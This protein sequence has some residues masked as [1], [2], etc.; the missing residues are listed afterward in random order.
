MN[1]QQKET[2]IAPDPSISMEEFLDLAMDLN[3]MSMKSFLQDKINLFLRPGIREYMHRPA[4]DTASA[5][6]GEIRQFLQTC[7]KVA[8]K[9]NT[10]AGDGFRIY[11]DKG[12]DTV[13]Q[14]RS[15][16]VDIL[17]PLIR[18]HPA[19]QEI[20]PDSLNTLRIHTV[21][22]SNEVRFFLPVI[23]STGADGAVTD[24]SGSTTRYHVFLSEDGSI[25]RAFREYPGKICQVTDRHH[26]TGYLFRQGQ[27]LPGIPACLECCRK[28]AFYV[29]EMRYI[30]WDVAVTQEGPVI[31][32]AN[33]ISGLF[34]FYQ[35][36]KECIAEA[37]ARSEIERMLAFGM[38]GVPYNRETVCIS[39]PLVK[40]GASL[41]DLWQLY[42]IL[43]QAALHRHGVEFYDRGFIKAGPA[44]RKNCSIRYL[45]EENAVLIQRGQRTD[46][47][48]QPDLDK[49][50]LSPYGDDN[51]HPC[52]SEEDFFAMDQAAMQ[53]AARIYRVLM[54]DMDSG[55]IIE[56]GNE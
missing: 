24:V 35:R 40:T 3:D 15:D 56:E 54:P 34:Y 18:Q 22:S 31:V 6:D 52:V 28:A 23:L 19:Y 33:N 14:I 9:R 21:R 50:G 51:G 11:T 1:P 13:A 2:V 43:L 44:V 17:E 12:A 8:G 48:P 45:E 7:G 5:W 30:G 26:N 38:E 16:G 39:E 27:K 55:S 32:E 42:L 49:R 37:G 53:E 46:R 47:I 10:A 29:P 4:L 36:A 41:P 25:I 20:Y